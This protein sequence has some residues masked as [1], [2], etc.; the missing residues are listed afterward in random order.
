MKPISALLFTAAI[1]L[2]F[3]SCVDNGN[4]P[5]KSDIKSPLEMTWTIDTLFYSE[6]AQTIMTSIYG[7]ASND[8]W[9]VGHSDMAYGSMWHYNGVKWNI[10]DIMEGN[11]ISSYSLKNL[12]GL[13]PNNIWVSGNRIIGAFPWSYKNLVFQYNGSRWIDRNSPV[14]G[15]L[16]TVFA[17]SENSV[18][19][20]GQ[21]GSISHFDGLSWSV[22]TIKLKAADI[23]N[24][25]IKKIVAYNKRLFILI[26]GNDPVR[27]GSAYYVTGELKNWTI[28]DSM[29]TNTYPFNFTSGDFNLYITPSKRLLSFG[30][31][32]I[33]EYRSGKWECLFYDRTKAILAVCGIS[34]NYMVGIGSASYA[35]FYDGSGWR[36]IEQIKNSVGNVQFEGVWTDGK[37]VFIVGYTT[38]GFPNKSI[39]WHGK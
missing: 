2:F 38:N 15:Q 13:A 5:V 20:G 17:E 4:E 14:N 27:A 23:S 37:E 10:V 25:F 21:K 9:V 39:I 12:S 26:I 28:V 8:I 30:N 1:L 34:D 11:A 36:R 18:W 29:V 35:I 16:V 31:S 22:D 32:G 33:W 3:N 19:A 24:Y 6:G 7:S